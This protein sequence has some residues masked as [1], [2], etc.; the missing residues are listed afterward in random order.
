MSLLRILGIACASL[1]I[2][3][4]ISSAQ[5]TYVGD[6]SLGFNDMNSGGQPPTVAISGLAIHLGLWVR[7]LGPDHPPSPLKARPAAGPRYG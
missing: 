6:P 4:G 7:W 1:L 2:L 5:V 3:A